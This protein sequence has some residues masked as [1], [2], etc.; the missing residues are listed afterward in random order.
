[1]DKNA[2][3][4]FQAD[5]NAQIQLIATIEQKLQERSQ[6]LEPDDIN[7]FLLLWDCHRS[8]DYCNP[9]CNKEVLPNLRGKM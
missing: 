8:L 9:S 2:L 1:M 3:I 7:A 6:N 4:I 5:V